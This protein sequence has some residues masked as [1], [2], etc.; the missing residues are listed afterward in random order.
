M[1]MMLQMLLQRTDSVIMADMFSTRYIHISES[2]LSTLVVHPIA[3]T[4]EL[5]R[6][7]S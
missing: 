3:L 5:S 4:E 7:S 1:Y 6:N 2:E